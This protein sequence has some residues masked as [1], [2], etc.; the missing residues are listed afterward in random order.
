M[1]GIV[2]CGG[3]G[4]RMGTEK[5]LLP[6]GAGTLLQHAIGRLRTGCSRVILSA[7]TDREHA[8]TADL[9]VGDPVPDQGPLGGLIAALEAAGDDL[10]FAVAVDQP[11]AD[12]FV[13]GIM[14]DRCR[15]SGAVAVCFRT[16]RGL[17]PLHAVYTSRAAAPLREAWERGERRLQ[18]AVES[19]DPLELGEESFAPEV[20][21]ARIRHMLSNV[22]TP[23]DLAAARSLL[24]AESVR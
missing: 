9:V 17:E 13:A 11:W 15:S 16:G 10:S 8:G 7:R 4:R 20:S 2:L 21:P 24:E 5:A 12:L 22:N 3:R 19:L 6:F 1:T 14:A 18:S 23:E